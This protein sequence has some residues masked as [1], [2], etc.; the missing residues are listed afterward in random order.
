MI[1][2][3]L[4]TVKYIFK[5]NIYLFSSQVIAMTTQNNVGYFETIDLFIFLIIRQVNGEKTQS[6]LQRHRYP[7]LRVQSPIFYCP[8]LSKYFF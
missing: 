3:S 2:S 5:V 6:I 8:V 7:W 4:N 1:D